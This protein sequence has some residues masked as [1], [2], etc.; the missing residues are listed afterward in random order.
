MIDYTVF[1]QRLIKKKNAKV[2]REEFWSQWKKLLE[3]VPEIGVK[4]VLVRTGGFE[5]PHLLA[6]PPQGSVST[7]PP[8]PHKESVGRSQLR[9][10]V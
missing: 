6:L 5:P 7:I 10:I 3:E 2:I 8:R 1:N 9:F 4:R